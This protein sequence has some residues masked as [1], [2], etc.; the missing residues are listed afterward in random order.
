[1]TVSEQADDRTP[2]SGMG[3]NSAGSMTATGCRV[4][5]LG[6][7]QWWETSERVEL[8]TGCRWPR[9]GALR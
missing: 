7:P 1:M 8:R 9:P 4:Q 2:T 3:R 5:A 6:A